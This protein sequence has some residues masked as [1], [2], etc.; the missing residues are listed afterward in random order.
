MSIEQLDH[1]LDE[2]EKEEGIKVEV[3]ETSQ[4]LGDVL[5]SQCVR[6]GHKCGGCAQCKAPET[7]EEEKMAA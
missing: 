1:F 4:E 3:E 6:C 2:L 7:F 5:A